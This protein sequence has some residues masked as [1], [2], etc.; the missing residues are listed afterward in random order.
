MAI[1]VLMDKAARA[2]DMRPYELR[3]KNLLAPGKVNAIGQ[4]FDEHSGDVA[5]CT[6]KVV[7]AL[8]DRPISDRGATVRVGRGIASFMKT[9]CMPAN[10]QSGARIKLNADGTVGLS[11]GAVEMGQ[12]SC[13]V[14]AQICAEALG[15]PT[16]K[17]SVL[18]EVD[19]FTTPYEWQTVA[20]HSTWGSGNAILA[21]AEDLKAKLRESAA[22]YFGARPADIIL[23]D[24]SALYNGESLGWGALSIGLRNPDG[25]ALTGPVEGIGFFVPEGIQNPD[26]DG[27]Q[28]NAA[29]DWTV[30]CVGAEVGVDTGTGTLHVYRLLICLDAGTIINPQNA[31]E[32]V[33]SGMVLSIGSALTERLCFS[34]D[35]GHIRN[36]SLT[37]YH[38]PGIEDMPESME[39]MFVQT[40]EKSGP[41]GAKGLGEHG[42]VAVVPALLNA[43]EDATGLGFTTLPVTADKVLASLKEVQP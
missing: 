31:I 41:Y 8:Y 7:A 9:P 40:P 3:L 21:A 32:Q 2:L 43:I 28:S 24:G 42:A 12:G 23:Q 16:E 36:A 29:A 1:E 38:I 33:K 10:C 4:R 13:T 11:I 18:K 17:V 14:L 25:S 26:P 35:R 39:V 37:D 6:E 27:G 22:A 20:S 15:L 19:T 30:G 5:Q 34:E